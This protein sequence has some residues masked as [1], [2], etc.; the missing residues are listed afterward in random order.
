M[1]HPDYGSRHQSQLLLE[2][3]GLK[4]SFQRMLILEY[5]MKQKNH[6]SAEM[7]Y[8]KISKEIPT[9]SRT[10]IYN[11][12][13]LFVDKGILTTLKSNDSEA[14]YDTL[15]NPHT[16]FHCS[17]C[18]RIIDIELDTPLFSKAEIEGNQVDQVQIHFKGICKNCQKESDGL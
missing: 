7:I 16:H 8:D 9:L 14:R 3:R 10:T 5:I 18:G 15:E 4:P 2:K 13:N 17:S 6:P 12:L 1:S 11:N